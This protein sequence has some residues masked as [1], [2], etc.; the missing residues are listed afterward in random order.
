MPTNTLI[1]KAKRI[2]E[3]TGST[4]KFIEKFSRVCKHLHKEG[5]KIY[6]TYPRCYCSQ[7][8]KGPKGK[9][10]ATYCNC[11]RGW[12]KALFEGATGKPIEVRMEE[13]MINGNNECKFRIIM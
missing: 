10:S 11:S 6:V 3:K 7:V 4:D 13:S 9:I 5:D 2:Y 8:N 12:I 1:K